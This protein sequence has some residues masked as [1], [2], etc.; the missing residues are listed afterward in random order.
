MAVSSHI[1]SRA[2]ASALLLSTATQ[3]AE[4]RTP[5]IDSG[6]TMTVMLSLLLVVSVIVL[7]AWLLRR[8][9]IG[10]VVGGHTIRVLAAA[11][12]GTRERV[13]L[14]DVNGHQLLLGVT[15]NNINT[16]QVYDEPVMQAA[17]VPGGDFA[18]KLGSLL[19]PAR[20]SS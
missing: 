18:S 11:S 7:L 5:S 1:F 19:N 20:K 2:G 13:L 6:I 9:G 4:A 10:S 16:L 14:V 15:P 12:V 8:A 17:A 3:A